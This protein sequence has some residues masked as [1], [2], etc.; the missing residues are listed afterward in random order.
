MSSGISSLPVSSALG[1]LS[2]DAS[3]PWAGGRSRV[4]VD[5]VAAESVVRKHLAPAV[6][7]LSLPLPEADTALR[8]SRA[9][10]VVSDS[11]VSG[12]SVFR[13]VHEASSVRGTDLGT[14]RIAAHLHA[15]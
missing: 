2:V 12:V 4:V 6:I 13:V 1:A 14:R 8:R 3:V 9:A 11:H 15:V 10:H 5:A 7:G